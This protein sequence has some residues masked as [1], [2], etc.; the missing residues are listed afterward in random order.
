MPLARGRE[1]RAGAAR[2]RV[3]ATSEW[4]SGPGVAL[5]PPVVCRGS[6]GGGVRATNGVVHS[7]QSWF[8][9]CEYS[10]VI[11][12]YR[13]AIHGITLTGYPTK[14]LGTSA[15]VPYLGV[16]YENT[17][18][19]NYYIRSSSKQYDLR[20]ESNL[21]QCCRQPRHFIHSSVASPT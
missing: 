19:Y 4:A 15:T 17:P 21:T 14:G 13:Y 12:W 3:R 7:F 11:D 18:A 16:E 2:P 9:F 10:K 5:H 8:C 1:A 6:E 20:V